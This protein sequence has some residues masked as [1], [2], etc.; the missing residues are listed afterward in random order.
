MDAF[1]DANGAETGTESD[2]DHI[3]ANL[4]H[5]SLDESQILKSLEEKAPKAD[6]ERIFK[7]SYAS[8]KVIFYHL[9][10]YFIVINYLFLGPS[11]F[12]L[13]KTRH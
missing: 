6:I 12:E 8:T 13:Y 7:T 4:S 1:R 2:L 3:E 10:I 11:S 5:M 9:T